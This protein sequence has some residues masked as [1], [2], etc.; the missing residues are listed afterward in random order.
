MRI[1]SLHPKYLDKKG[2]GG[3]WLESIIA[4]NALK[5]LREGYKNHPQLNRFK[6]AENP[7]DCINQYMISIYY[8]SKR[9]KYKYNRNLINWDINATMIPVTL[10]QIQYETIHLLNKL[11]VRDFKKYK[12]VLSCPAIDTH[13]MF[14]V[15]DGDVENWEIAKF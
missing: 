14:Y 8:E 9:R 13:P 10:G 11:K 2:L 1:W 6:K 12:E 15:V 3:L 4:K 5:G 7:V